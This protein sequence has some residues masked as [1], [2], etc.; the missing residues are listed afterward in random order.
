VTAGTRFRGFTLIELLVVIAIIGVLVAI[1]LP[2][3]QSAR[4]AARR[5]HCINNIKQL[6]LAC[7]HYESEN[8]ALPYARKADLDSPYTWTQLILPEIEQQDVQDLYYDLFAEDGEISPEWEYRPTGPDPRK[9]AARLTQ[10]SQ[11]YCPSDWTPLPNETT[12]MN[13]AHWRGNYRGC[14]G[15]S[16]PLRFGRARDTGAF[17]IRQ[18]QGSKAYGLLDGGPPEQVRIAEVVDGTSHTLLISEGIAP[19][20]PANIWGSQLGEVIHGNIGGALFDAVLGPN[21]NEPDLIY[22]GCP[23][24]FSD[25]FPIE[26]PAPCRPAGDPLRAIAAARSYHPGGVV[27]SKVDGSVTFVLDG[28]DLA[29]WQAAGTKEGAEVEPTVN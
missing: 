8:G 13:W 25:W 10:I 21:S 3:V 27:A 6:T 29:T 11:F 1:L 14:V 5:V 4:E 15:Y 22:R 20:T 9:R 26:Y 19:N 16:E 28:I 17:A 18:R 2:A 7:L 12:S 23:I 24:M